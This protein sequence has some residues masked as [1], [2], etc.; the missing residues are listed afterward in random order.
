MIEWDNDL[1]PFAKLLAEADQANAVA[2]Q[3]R[4]PENSRAIAC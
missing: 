2:A 1:P 4:S 3:A